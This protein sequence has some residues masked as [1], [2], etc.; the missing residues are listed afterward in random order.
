MGGTIN[1]APVLALPIADSVVVEDTPWTF[2]LPAGTFTDAD[3][4]TLTLTARLADGS[5]LP[6]WISFDSA[7]RTFSGTPPTEFSGTLDIRVF[8]TDGAYAPAR[9]G[10]EVLVNTT[11]AF[12]QQAPTIT[13]LSNGGFVVSWQ[14]DSAEDVFNLGRS[15]GVR[16]QVYDA[17]GATVGGEITVNTKT[18]N[19]QWQPSV[20][21][22]ANGGFVIAWTDDI[23]Q[24]TT[25]TV[26]VGQLFSATGAKIGGEFRVSSDTTTDRQGKAPSITGLVDGG[27]VVSWTEYGFDGSYNGVR[28]QLFNAT[29]AKVGTQ[30]QVNT[31]AVGFQEASTITGQ[32]NGGFVAAWYDSYGVGGGDIRAQIFTAAGTKVGGEFRVHVGVVGKQHSPAITALAEGGFVVSWTDDEAGTDDT[33]QAVRAQI[34]TATGGMVGDEFL[35]N[36][37][38]AA[39]R[40]RTSTAAST[41]ASPRAT[42]RPPSPTP[43]A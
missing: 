38:T 18:L 30:F 26:V 6:R 29:G 31:Q 14:D 15:F 25:G 4:P 40:R 39:S 16:A 3:T 1:A 27:F 8:A 28:A 13:G 19:D 11:T 20:T 24:G 37:T 9:V 5:P 2:V 32:A 10:T 21:D 42:A 43:S 33:T 17:N 23:G 7:T 22:L 34:Y 41:S 35:V 12:Q 36:T